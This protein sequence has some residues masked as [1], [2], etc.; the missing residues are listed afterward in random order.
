MKSNDEEYLDS[1]LNSAQKNT[2]PK[3]ALSRMS[4]QT[5]GEASSSGSMDDSGDIGALVSNSGGNEDLNDIENMLERLDRDELVDDK[6]ADLLDSIAA[7]S[8]SS[9]PGFTVG[10]EP[11]TKDVRDPEEIAL[12][13]AIADAERMDAEIQSGKFNEAPIEDAAPAPLVEVEEGD[14]ALS[15]MAPEVILPEDNILTNEGALASDANE[16]P[17]EILTDLLDE[18]PGNSLVEQT[19]EENS[20]SLSQVLDNLPEEEK[21]LDEAALDGNYDDL[22]L[23]DLESE[24]E[25]VLTENVAE[26]ATETIPDEPILT[27]NPSLQEMEDNLSLDD[28]DLG[29]MEAEIEGIGN[30]LNAEE[31][32]PEELPAEDNPIE[33]VPLEEAAAEAPLDEALMAEALVDEIPDLEEAPLTGEAASEEPALDELALEE[34]SL[35]EAALE[36]P[37]PEEMEGASADTP[38]EDSLD[39]MEEA[40]EEMMEGLGEEP[41]AEE[42]ADSNSDSGDDFNLDD[43]E[44][45][46]DDLLGDESGEDTTEGEVADVAPSEESSSAAAEGEDGGDVSIPDLDALMNSL[47][48]DEIEDIESTAK[49]DEEAGVAETEELPKEDILDALTDDGAYGGAEEPSLGDLASIPERSPEEAE[50]EEGGKDK[51]KKKKGGLGAL[52]AKLFHALTAEDEEN[53]E[54]LASL[55]D[56]NQTV[57]NEL[58]GEEKPKK[59]KKKKEKKPKKEKPKKEKK[60]KEKKPPK[61]KKEKKPK[62]PKDPGAPEKAMSPKKI[63]ISGIFAASIGILFL[64]PTLVLPERIA[65]EKAQNAYVHKEYTTAYKMLYGK[66]KTEDQEIIYEQSRVLAW[67][68]R[69][70]AGYENYVAMNMKEEALDMLLRGMRNKED[71]L[72]EAAKFNVEIQVQSVYDNI[73]SLLSENYGLNADEI[74]EIN[75]I[76]KDRDYTIRLMEIVGTLQS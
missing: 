70:V 11:S 42:K 29:A 39:S 40:M 17:E 1:L 57:L 38:A 33:E 16:S 47:A 6:M 56:E 75:S 3:S 8:A 26:T 7:P 44:A 22:S 13:E 65:G 45:S 32:I 49:Q 2:N 67:A 20:E 35:E 14:D 60:P 4:S 68:E 55:T 36:E 69:Y 50:G 41:A 63:A 24:M 66:E 61:P 71:L 30:E 18:M 72:E 58:A 5:K 21:K 43:L 76:K 37:A 64:I 23:K 28:L 31:A 53:T 19:V 62:P 54:G 51:K 9:L 34:P 59:E 27:E 48:N 10:S 25:D 46:L 74:S 12:D 52:F 15:E 73:E